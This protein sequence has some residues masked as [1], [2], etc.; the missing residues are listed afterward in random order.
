[1]KQSRV[2]WI[3]GCRFV[4]ILAILLATS[5]GIVGC[6]KATGGGKLTG[7]NGEKITLGFQMR[8]ENIADTA[9]LLGQ[10]QFKD[11]D[12]DVAFHGVIDRSVRAITGGELSATCEE[13]DEALAAEELQGI[14][15]WFNPITPVPLAPLGTYTPQ[16]K[17]L[18]DGGDLYVMVVDGD[19]ATATPCPEGQD[20]VFVELQGGIYGG[21]I[22]GGCLD[23]GNLTVFEE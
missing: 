2:K 12:Q 13:L 10:V 16:P 15:G 4:A 7:M 19:S 14:F 22:Q 17:I 21:Y 18:G 3:H 5:V 6:K 8:C 11:H 20:A 23:H 9:Y 1:M